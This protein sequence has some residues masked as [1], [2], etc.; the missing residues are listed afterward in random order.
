MRASAVTRGNVAN[1]VRGLDLREY[2]TNNLMILY[3][4]LHASMYIRM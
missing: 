2:Y 4:I 1:G 3:Y